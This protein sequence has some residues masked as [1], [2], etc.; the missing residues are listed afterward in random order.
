MLLG[1]EQ[2][3]ERLRGVDAYVD[4]FVGI[5]DDVASA[6]DIKFAHAA[7]AIAAF[8]AVNWR[9]DN[10]PFD[11]FLRGERGAMSLSA[12]AGMRI[13]YSPRKGNCV[14]CHSGTFQTDQSF[15]AI[16]M[17]QVGTGK[18]DGVGY[19]DF[20][21]ERV[22]G[23]SS[24]D[25]AIASTRK[26]IDSF[27]RVIDDLRRNLSD[28]YIDEDDLSFQYVDAKVPKYGP[29]DQTHEKW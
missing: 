4:Q 14:S 17:P 27:N 3:A 2:L 6:A 19:E 26:L 1:L 25:N 8:E 20:G 16:A 15:R 10:S 5:Y 11:R 23:N 18:G 12:L 29:Y 24:M 13:F 9:A 28:G 21:R 7:N 22:T